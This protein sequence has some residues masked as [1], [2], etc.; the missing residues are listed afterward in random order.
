MAGEG[1]EARAKAKCEPEHSLCSVAITVLVGVGMGWGWVPRCS[2]RSPE[3]L[4]QAGSVPSKV[5]VT[6]VL[7]LVPSPQRGAVLKQE[8]PEWAP[9]AGGAHSVVVLAHHS[10]PQPTAHL[11]PPQAPVLAQRQ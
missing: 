8:E 3:V 9:D 11:L 10:L 1:G 7:A 4:V 6:L 2:S 5:A